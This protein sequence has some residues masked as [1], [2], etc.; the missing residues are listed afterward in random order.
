MKNVKWTV[1]PD[2]NTLLHYPPLKDTDWKKLADAD[3]VHVVLCMQV[4]HE[5]DQK[6]DDP[7]LSSRAQRAI[8]EIK[9]IRAA[10]STIRDGVTLEVFVV[11][12]R[13]A[14]FPPALSPDSGDDKIIYLVNKYIEQKNCTDVSVYSEDNGMLLKCEAHG[15]PAIEP[16]T[17]AR[18][19]TPQSE[20]EK[21][22][23]AAIT[24]LNAIKSQLP[25]NL[26]CHKSASR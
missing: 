5:L 8:K 22:Y 13:V 18:L 6:K 20:Q 21:K 7:R 17:D 14:D 10:G 12:P 2:T 16:D 4:I 3:L 19:A 24:E 11:E 1:F 9:A 25:Q 23:K 26:N 15:I